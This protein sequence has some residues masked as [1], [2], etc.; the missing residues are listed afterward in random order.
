[1]AVDDVQAALDKIGNL[2]GTTVMPPM[3]VPDGPTIGLFAD[4][5]GNLI[6]LMKSM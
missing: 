1:M 2:G 3:D 5:A 6:G 4:P